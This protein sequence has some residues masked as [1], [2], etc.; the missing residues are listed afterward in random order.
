ML[1]DGVDRIT[2][3]SEA[4]YGSDRE[5]GMHQRWLC[6]RASEVNTEVDGDPLWKESW[7]GTTLQD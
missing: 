4:V 5:V 3:L 1:V 2:I 7:C 6:R